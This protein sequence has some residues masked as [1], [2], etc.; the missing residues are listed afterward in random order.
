MSAY[1]SGSFTVDPP[2]APEHFAYLRAFARSRRVRRDPARLGPDPVRERAG[3]PAGEEGGYYVG[4][5]D[6]RS[7][8]DSNHAPSGQPGVWCPWT[9]GD[10][11]DIQWDGREKASMFVAWLHYIV[12]HFLTPWGYRIDG[13]VKF[14]DDEDAGVL[15][16]TSKGLVVRTLDDLTP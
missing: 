13:R 16:A 5:R 7:V 10:E 1:F 6:D 8:V 3:L 9:V 4:D 12:D 11:G 14:I 2:M 15:F